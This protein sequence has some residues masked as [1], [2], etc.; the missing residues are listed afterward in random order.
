MNHIAYPPQHSA[1]APPSSVAMV[2]PPVVAE[3]V[4]QHPECLAGQLRDVTLLSVDISG[5]ASAVELLSPADYYDLLGNVTEVITEIVI[6]HQGTV[7]DCHGHGLMAVWNAPMDQ[8]NHATLACSAA[9][10]MLDYLPE[11]SGRWRYRLSEPL[12][13]SVGV[14]TGPTLVGN[15]GFGDRIMYIPHGKG[16]DLVRRV[17]SATSCL[18]LPLLLSKATHD[19]LSGEFLC[20]RVCAARLPGLQ[21][22]L[23]LYAAYPASDAPSM[24]DDLDRYAE[25]L[26]WFE[27]GNLATAER[28]LADLATRES[29]T[30]APFL[31]HEVQVR[32]QAAQGRRASDVL[33]VN[34]G[35]VIEIPDK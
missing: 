29:R 3:Y 9:Q 11:A 20:Q 35:P 4:Q 25:A 15:A 33:T 34:L 14:H 26:E 10:E 6:T 8:E 17:Q 7:V 12:Q 19:S 23:D 18:E 2:F 32:M 28:L 21:Q 24:R 22:K 27:A 31:A 16:V 13:L 5:F 30:P 1:L